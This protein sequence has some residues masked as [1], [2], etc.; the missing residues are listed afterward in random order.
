MT[1][2]SRTSATGSSGVLAVLTDAQLRDELDRVAAAVGVRVVHA[3]GSSVSRK[4]WAAAAA[5]VLDA[6]AADWCGRAALPRR[7]HVTVLTV[8]E[9][10]TATWAAAIAAGAQHVLRVPEQEDEL[11]RGLA[12]SRGVRA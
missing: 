2:R 1:S 12:R 10:A 11:I 9:P 6:A 5:V 8:A 7:A 4:T 3:G